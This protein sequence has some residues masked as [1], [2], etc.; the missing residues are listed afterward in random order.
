MSL[1]KIHS[2]DQSSR[3]MTS[4]QSQTSTEQ[5]DIGPIKRTAS[6]MNVFKL[7]TDCSVRER[8]QQ[9]ERRT[10]ERD[11]AFGGEE[12]GGREGCSQLLSGALS[13]PAGTIL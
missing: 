4:S 3:Q 1:L 12:G 8:D 10:V 7:S 11:R 5:S 6:Q 9:T 13:E 2:S